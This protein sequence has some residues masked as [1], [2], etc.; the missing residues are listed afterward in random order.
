MLLK[1]W[2][3]VSSS[4][5]EMLMGCIWSDVQCDI[6]FVDKIDI[7]M[8]ACHIQVRVFYIPEPNEQI[9]D[10]KQCQC[11]N[12]DWMWIR[13]QRHL[14]LAKTGQ[15]SRAEYGK[16]SPFRMTLC[17]GQS[18]RQ[19]TADWQYLNEFMGQ[20]IVVPLSNWFTLGRAH[21]TRDWRED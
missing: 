7:L 13:D 19:L 8:G 12:R 16:L 1:T 14:R 11:H 20:F 3:I 4:Y 10:N 15:S 9:L 18:T 21:S 5:V 2:N 6:R 17:N